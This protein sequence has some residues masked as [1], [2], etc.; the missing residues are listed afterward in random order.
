MTPVSDRRALRAARAVIAQRGDKQRTGDI[1]YLTY[2][3]ILTVA[4]AVFP[5]LRLVV[6]GLATP[7]VQALTALPEVVGVVT[8][9]GSI[10]VAGALLLGPI[11]GPAIPRPFLAQFLLGSPIVRRLGLRRPFLSS[12]FALAFFFISAA[13]MLAIANKVSASSAEGSGDPQAVAFLIVSALAF[14]ILLSIDWLMGQTLPRW[15]TGTVAAI[16]LATGSVAACSSVATLTPLATLATTVTPWGWLALSSQGLGAPAPIVWPTAALVISSVSLVVVPRLLDSVSAPKVLAQSLRWLTTGILLTTGD[17]AAAV[18]GFRPPPTRARHLHI[19]FRGP[20]ILT[21][22][23]RDALAIIRFPM[24]L[25][26]GIVSVMAAGW[27]IGTIAVVPEG[28]RWAL[29]LPGALLAYLAAGVWC[30]GLRNSSSNAAASSLYGW[31]VGPLTLAHAVAPLI[32]V[33]VFGGAGVLLAGNAQTSAVWWILLAVFTVIVRVYDSAKGPLPVL[34]MMPIVTPVGDLSVLNVLLWQSDAILLALAI[35]GGLSLA[36]FTGAS[37]A[38]AAF[39]SLV[40]GSAVVALL[41][42]RRVRAM[43][44]RS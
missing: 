22:F 26:V 21:V 11:R 6:L 36:Y 35:G 24:R 3:V 32:A 43:D 5:V 19:T 13:G 12:S 4:I 1:A 42:L 27:L 29:A 14:S 39:L 15:V 20:M 31:A 38:V 9:A 37:G 41:A 10:L 34:L 8:L 40:L 16:V 18:G 28:I 44:R 25:A 17:A 7:S 23:T 30:D 2:T 33:I